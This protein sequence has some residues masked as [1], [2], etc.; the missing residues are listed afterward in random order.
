MPQIPFSM[1]AGD[2]KFHLE[3]GRSFVKMPLPNADAPETASTRE[4]VTAVAAEHG[5]AVAFANNEMVF[6]LVR[7]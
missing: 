7:K 2:L 4:H 3:H 6:T 5:M 1:I